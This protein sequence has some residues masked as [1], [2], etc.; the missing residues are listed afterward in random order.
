MCPGRPAA[1]AR[2]SLDAGLEDVEGGEEGDGVEIALDGGAVADGA[3]AFVEGDAPVEAEDVGAGFGHG[4]EHGGGVDAEVDDG[5]AE[6]L[7]ALDEL[8]GGGEAVLAIVGDGEGAGPGVED[9]DAVGAGFDLL[10]RVGDEDG[11]ELLHEQGP[12]AVV[13]VHH[14]LGFDVVARAAAF[15]H[16]AGEGEGRAAEADDAEAV[17]VGARGRSGR[18]L[19]RWPWRRR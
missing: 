5:D 4:G 15:D 3:P 7:D 9:L 17:A 2:T 10:L 1:R 13:G 16:V 12:G 11:D 8:G 18:R 19:F 6:G 14:L